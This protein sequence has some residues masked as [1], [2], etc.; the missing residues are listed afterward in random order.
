MFEKIKETLKHSAIYGLGNVA[1][2]LVGFVLLPLY[3]AHLTVEDYGILSIFEIT[4]AVL[5][6]I[7]P[8]G[9]PQSYM[10]F[11][12]L[13][14]Y[15]NKQ[16]ELLYTN[17]IILLGISVTFLVIAY[18]LSPVITNYFKY[19]VEFSILFKI[20]FFVVAL[21]ILS[22]LISNFLRTKERSVLYAVSN[23]TKLIITLVGN[24]YFVAVAQ[25]GVRGILYSTLIGEIVYFIVLFPALLREMKPQFD[26][27]IAKESFKFGFPLIFTTLS[28]LLL[29]MGDRYVLKYL[30]NYQEVGLYNLGYK[31]A[32][33]LNMLLIQAF[34]MGM[35]PIAYKMYGQK[36]DKRFYSKL[37]TY[38]VFVLA[39]AGLALALFSKELLQIL[40]LNKDYW[41][42]YTVVP[43]IILGYILSG[44]KYNASMLLYLTKKTKYTAYLTFSAA[45]LNIGLNFLFIPYWKM[46]GAAV[47]TV[48]SFLYLYIATY[49]VGR[50]F[51]PV[52]YENKKLFT[53]IGIAAGFF[54]LALGLQTFNIWIT[55]G[56]KVVIVLLYPVILYFLG[57]YEQQELKRLR[58]AIRKVIRGDFSSII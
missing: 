16:N 32:G 13:E 6:Q 14:E 20:A 44:A 33:V 1:T 52:K 50:K 57:F 49:F 35:L 37:Q 43:V 25:I 40:A 11:Y 34:Q 48:L 24:I 53:A 10:R 21:R 31:I 19:T 4:I 7:L 51:Y 2:K 42:A 41:A 30:V 58:S 28:G 3:T 9:Q 22:N 36:G 8:M 55:L 39:W 45:L 26:V 17:F 23:T 38:F 56:I 5:S 12:S 47:A 27:L 29:N 54:L 46:V 18:V 15:E